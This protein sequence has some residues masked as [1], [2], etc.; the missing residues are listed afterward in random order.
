MKQEDVDAYIAESNR[1]KKAYEGNLR[2]LTGMEVDYISDDFGPHIDY[3]HSLPLD[4]R[5]GSVHFVRSQDGHPVDVDGPAERFLK[6]LESEYAGDLD[7]VVH[8][9]FAEE[10]EMLDKGGFDIIGHLNK[11]GDNGSHA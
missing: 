3:F 2:I 6:Y 4:Y 11:I 10:L 5:I 9:Y 1:L 7:Y 8:T